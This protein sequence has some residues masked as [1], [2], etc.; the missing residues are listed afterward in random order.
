[1]AHFQFKRNSL[2]YKITVS[3]LILTVLNVSLFTFMIFENQLDLI[4]ENT[5]L[6]SETKSNSIRQKMESVLSSATEI[7]QTVLASVQKELKYIG[8]MR[9]SLFEE[10]CNIIADAFDGKI[11]PSK[12]KANKDEIAGII[13]SIQKS[14]FENRVFYHM[15]DRKNNKRL[16]K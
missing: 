7:N 11:E 13:K 6:N 4:S 9:F 1:M 15:M 14:S 2:S 3:Y 10:N 5:L 12:R 8:I 16:K